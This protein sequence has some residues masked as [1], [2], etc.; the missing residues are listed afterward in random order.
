[1]GIGYARGHVGG[2]HDI[3]HGPWRLVRTQD[4]IPPPLYSSGPKNLNAHLPR[5]NYSLF[6]RTNKNIPRYGYVLA[7]YTQKLMTVL[8]ERTR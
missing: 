4:S 5:V 2:G 7:K 3:M 6:K 1:M 8:D